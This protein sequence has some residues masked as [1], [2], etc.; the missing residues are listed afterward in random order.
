MSASSAGNTIRNMHTVYN[1][2]RIIMNSVLD[3]DVKAGTYVFAPGGK[4]LVFQNETELI[5]CLASHTLV[6]LP[7]F[8]NSHD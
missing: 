4:E 3:Y 5:R 6:P 2:S 7:P 8:T 1:D